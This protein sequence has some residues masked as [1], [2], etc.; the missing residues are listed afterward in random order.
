[1]ETMLPYIGFV[2][3]IAMIESFLP[4]FAVLVAV[5]LIVGETLILV[6]TDKYWPLS[7]DD[8][9]ACLLLLYAAYSFEFLLGKVLMLIAWCF[10]AGNLYAMLFTRMDPVTGTRERLVPLAALMTASLA[11]GALTLFHITGQQI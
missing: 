11:G 7:L 5:I 4:F 10:M 1:M 8:Y 2:E 3:F 6:R 9:L